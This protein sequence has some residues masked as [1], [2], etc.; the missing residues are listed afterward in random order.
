MKRLYC[1]FTV[2]SSSWWSEAMAEDENGLREATV[3]SGSCAYLSDDFILLPGL[4]L[5]LLKIWFDSSKVACIISAVPFCDCHSC[6]EYFWCDLSFVQYVGPGY[7]IMVVPFIHSTK[8]V[9]SNSASLC[10]SI[11]WTFS[12]H[13]LSTNIPLDILSNF[14]IPKESYRIS[15]C[16]TRLCI[17]CVCLHTWMYPK[18][19]CITTWK[20]RQNFKIFSPWSHAEPNNY[21]IWL[22]KTQHSPRML[23]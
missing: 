8:A 22:I 11:A 14:I 16:S 21:P 20:R 4:E 1:F 3:K 17:L 6:I 7:T 5:L 9:C 2:S 18:M 19:C 15:R 13:S 12:I 23:C 10:Y